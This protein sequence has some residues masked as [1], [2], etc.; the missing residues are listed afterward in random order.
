MS[1]C[2]FCKIVTGE[3]PGRKIYEDDEVLAFH[4]IHPVAPVHFLLIPKRHIVSLAEC[5]AGD[6]DILG[7]MMLLAPKLAHEQ[8][9]DAGFRTVINTG[10][11]GGQEVFHLHVHVFGGGA[12][13]P[14][15]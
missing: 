14:G 12:G 2:I 3:I 1:D 13:L 4:D 11:G 5:G 8:G 7:R 6:R 15:F 10:H 9:L